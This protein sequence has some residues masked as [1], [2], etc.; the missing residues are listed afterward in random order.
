MSTPIG[1]IPTNERPAPAGQTPPS[2]AEH[3]AGIS[4]T[5]TSLCCLCGDANDS[6]FTQVWTS[7]S[8]FLSSIWTWLMGWCFT[9]ETP[10]SRAVAPAA[11]VVNPT[12]ASAPA[13]VAASPVVA[14]PQ[15]EPLPNPPVVSAQ[16]P[17]APSPVAA[18]EPVATPA[19]ASP[20]SPRSARSDAP[21]APEEDLASPAM[22]QLR[23]ELIGHAKM[24]M[25]DLAAEAFPHLT[26]IDC[27]ALLIFK[28]GGHLLTLARAEVRQ[29][30]SP[31]NQMPFLASGTAALV[32][33]LK[34]RSVMPNAQMEIKLMLIEKDRE[35]RV[36]RHT[37]ASAVTPTSTSGEPAYFTDRPTPDHMR[38]SMTELLGD[39]GVQAHGNQAPEWARA[40]DLE[41]SAVQNQRELLELWI[42]Q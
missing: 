35:G 40:A 21:S 29:A 23:N 10:A 39:W 38:S 27:K 31:K 19:A 30:Y 13:P 33:A 12:A 3:S 20:E 14:P 11:V 8:S 32:E 9:Q 36:Q 42:T 41:F 16:A 5:P 34:T 18:P 24:S 26:A 4:D 22:T 7:I 17:R 6:I 37:C 25:I 28:L 15:V 1:N 2:P